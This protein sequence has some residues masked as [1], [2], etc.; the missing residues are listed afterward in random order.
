[1]GS[2]CVIISVLGITPLIG[3]TSYVRLGG[4]TVTGNL[5]GAM[6]G[7][8][9]RTTVLWVFSGCMVL[10]SCANLSMAC[11]WISTIVKWICGTGLLIMCISSLAALVDYS[12]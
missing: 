5:V 2:S 10:N 7:T 6:V 3:L 8:L 4:G 11:N 9:L 12:V 1:M